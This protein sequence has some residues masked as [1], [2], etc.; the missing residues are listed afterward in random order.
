MSMMCV[1]D[2]PRMSDR[3]KAD[4][5]ST[6]GCIALASEILTA[7]SKEYIRARQAYNR[8]PGNAS[9]RAHW[10]T[11]RDFYLSDYYTVLSCGLVDAQAVLDQLDALAEG[12]ST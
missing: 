4:D 1:D 7:A 10:L 9:L 8:K 2:M 3:L 5:L 12:I 6:E 11:C